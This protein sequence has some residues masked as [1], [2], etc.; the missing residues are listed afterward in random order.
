MSVGM[1][2]LFLPLMLIQFIPEAWLIAIGRMAANV[3]PLQVAVWI[4]IGLL[5]L[6]TILITIARRLFQRSKLILD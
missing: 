1:L 4:A 5:V 3:E 6:E 2:V